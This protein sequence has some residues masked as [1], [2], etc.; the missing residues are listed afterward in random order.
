MKQP[1]LG[2]IKKKY[3]E[4]LGLK[5]GKAQHRPKDGDKSF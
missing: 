2:E 5:D 3:L 4:S 1:L